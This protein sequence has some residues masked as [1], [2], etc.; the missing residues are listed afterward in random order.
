MRPS[1]YA[2][3]LKL[4]KTIADMAATE[5]IASEAYFVTMDMVSPRFTLPHSF[6]SAAKS[7][8]L[9]RVSADPFLRG[10]AAARLLANL[11]LIERR[12]NLLV[13]VGVEEGG[14]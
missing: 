5:K 9:T 2:R 3:A 7:P 11:Q 4:A 14:D 13:I 1:S 8:S 12:N 6:F 10:R